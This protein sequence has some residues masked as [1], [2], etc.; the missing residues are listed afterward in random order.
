[1]ARRPKTPEMDELERYGFGVYDDPAEGCEHEWT[2][3]VRYEHPRARS[4]GARA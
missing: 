2:P 3:W 4:S 1:M